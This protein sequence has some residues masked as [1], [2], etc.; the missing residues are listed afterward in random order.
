METEAEVMKRTIEMEHIG[1]YQFI[2]RFGDERGE[3]MA[4]EPVPLGEGKGA[5]AARI[6]GAAIAN[7]LS[8]SLLF[9][10]NKSRANVESMKSTAEVSIVRNERGRM[11]IEHVDV[12]IDVGADAD[13]A[14]KL[15]RC[16]GLFEDFCV[17]TASVRQGIPVNV[18]VRDKEGNKYAVANA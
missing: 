9:C 1:G 2:V 12:G 15:A 4:D 14:Q 7:C 17:V 3:L 18:A 16:S 6:L 13:T 11:R 10:M 5:D 8:A